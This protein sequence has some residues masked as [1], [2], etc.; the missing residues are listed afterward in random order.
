MVPT[1]WKRSALAMA[2]LPAT[3]KIAHRLLY[4]AKVGANSNVLLDNEIRF[5]G[6]ILSD[7]HASASQM[8]QDIWVLHETNAK[9]NGYFCEFGAADGR[10]VSNTWLLERDFD[11]TG[12]LAEPAPVWH[13][14]LRRNRRCAI[15]DK[16]V[17]SESGRFQTFRETGRPELS[18]L[19]DFAVSDKHAPAR[20]EGH[21]FEVE[22]ISLNDLLST[23]NAPSHIDYLSIDTEGSE[24]QILKSFDFHRYHIDLISVEHNHGA[25]EKRLDE[26]LTAQGFERCF[27]NYSFFDGWYKNRQASK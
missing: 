7:G 11:W 16:C 26:F 13:E 25:N 15:S 24:L 14:Q 12:I 18:T 2:S 23:H 19:I 10:Y 9:R 20:A 6:R 3:K 17:W 8:F 21:D 27:R 4:F 5:I 1:S 22:T